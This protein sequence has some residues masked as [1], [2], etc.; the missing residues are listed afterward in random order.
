M[1]LSPN[2]SFLSN[3]RSKRCC[4]F[5][6]AAL[7]RRP[8]SRSAS[9]P[10]SYPKTLGRLHE[11]LAQQLLHARG[12]RF[13]Q[14]PSED[15]SKREHRVFHDNPIQSADFSPIASISKPHATG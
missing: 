5:C 11:D 1:I 14:P 6:A 12:F 8:S 4:T 3:S 13:L 9:R 7:S 10:K 15:E 2:R